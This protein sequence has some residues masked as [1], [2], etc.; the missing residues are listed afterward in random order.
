[1][2]NNDLS[3]QIKR[4]FPYKPTEEQE[5]AVKSFAEFLFSP[6]ADSVFLMK[7]YAG[8]GKTTLTSA[9]VCTLDSLQRKV[10]LLAPTGRAA[11]VF[12]GYAEHPAYTI[13][14][15]IYR[16]KVFSNETDNFVA[17]QNLHRNTL[18]IVDEASM[19]ANEGL[20]GG[21]FGNGRLLDDLVQYVYNG[22]GCRLMLI[23]DTAQLPPIGE[24]ESPALS[25][26]ALQG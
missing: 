26:A 14:K 23:G 21:H 10:I 13:H 4:N 17:N 25:V 12:S 5:N 6:S 24:E 9:L 1:M 15:K 16:Q 7:G 2:L 19:I 18:F 22:L 8:T 3:Q 20:S 11:K